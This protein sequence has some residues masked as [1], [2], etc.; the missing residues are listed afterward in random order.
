MAMNRDQWPAGLPSLLS[1]LFHL[2]SSGCIGSYMARVIQLVKMRMITNSSKSSCLLSF[3]MAFSISF[4]IFTSMLYPAPLS[5]LERSMVSIISDQM[6][7]FSPL[8]AEIV[9]KLV[10]KPNMLGLVSTAM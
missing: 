4:H 5:C 9:N 3:S 2:A 6:V 1:V 8:T 7:F 10:Q